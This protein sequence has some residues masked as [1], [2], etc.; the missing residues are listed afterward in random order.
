[1]YYLVYFAA[2]PAVRTLLQARDSAASS[3]LLASCAVPKRHGR[4]MHSCRN[5]MDDDDVNLIV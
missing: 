2:T 3:N 4:V 5:M 1:M